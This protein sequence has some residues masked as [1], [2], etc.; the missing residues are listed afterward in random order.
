MNFFADQSSHIIISAPKEALNA[1]NSIHFDRIAMTVI[2]EADVVTTT[3]S[4]KC[5]LMKPLKNS[6]KLL[7]SNTINK[8][9][10][11]LSDYHTEIQSVPL[12]ILNGYTQCEEGAKIQNVLKI[13]RTL[14]KLT[15]SVQCIIYCR[16]RIKIFTS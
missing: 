16:V 9:V 14:S 8:A 10:D 13:Y 3:Q 1:K 5:E 7:T 12:R 6:R 15:S 4:V 2:D 11:F